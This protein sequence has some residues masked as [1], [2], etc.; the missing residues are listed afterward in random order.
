[1]KCFERNCTDECTRVEGYVEYKQYL[2]D[3]DYYQDLVEKAIGHPDSYSRWK[4]IGL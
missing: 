2:L 4:L 1:M 3:R